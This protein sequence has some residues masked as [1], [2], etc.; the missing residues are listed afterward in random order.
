MRI[1]QSGRF[2]EWGMPFAT[3]PTPQTRAG[4]ACFGHAVDNVCCI[5][6]IPGHFVQR[7]GACLGLRCD[8]TYGFG[9]GLDAPRGAFYCILDYIC[10]RERAGVP[11]LFIKCPLNSRWCDKKV[12]FKYKYPLNRRRGEEVSNNVTNVI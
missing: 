9:L 1:H 10:G 7:I 8:R 12:S 6:V 5:G 11:K 2:Y 3:R 4:N